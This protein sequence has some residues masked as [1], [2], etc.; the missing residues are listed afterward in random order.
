MPESFV[1]VN[2]A[3]CVP[4]PK[5]LSATGGTISDD[6]PLNENLCCRSSEN[7]GLICASIAFV[8]MG[9]VEPPLKLYEGPV[10][11]LNYTAKLNLF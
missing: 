6:G 10:L 9:G 7:G 11:P 2:L 8:A 5:V 3:L 1:K 4:P